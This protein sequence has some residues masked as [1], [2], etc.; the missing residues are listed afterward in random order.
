MIDIKYKK[1]FKFN[2]AEFEKKMKFKNVNQEI[3]FN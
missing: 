2:A 3:L 1:P